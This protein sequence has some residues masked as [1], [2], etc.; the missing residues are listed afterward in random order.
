MAL[1][2]STSSPFSH[3]Q[4]L[5]WEA[6]QIFLSSLLLSGVAVSLRAGRFIADVS[7]F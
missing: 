7:F 2:L 1:L 4:P 6:V 3:P 5:H